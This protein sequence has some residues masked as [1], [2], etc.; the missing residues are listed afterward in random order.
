MSCT[1]IALLAPVTAES[2]TPTAEVSLA[3]AC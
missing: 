1:C 3:V 2:F